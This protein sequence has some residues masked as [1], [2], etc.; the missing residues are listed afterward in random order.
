M[1]AGRVGEAIYGFQVVGWSIEAIKQIRPCQ[2]SG[3]NTRLCFQPFP[4]ESY[5]L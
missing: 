2:P 4:Q 5:R 1:R 3:I